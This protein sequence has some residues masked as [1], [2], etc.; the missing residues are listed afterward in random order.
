MAPARTATKTAGNGVQQPVSQCAVRLRGQRRILAGDVETIR[1]AGQG[2]TGHGIGAC[3]AATTTLT[4]FADAAA[5]AELLWIAERSKRWIVLI[6][7]DYRITWEST[8]F[9]R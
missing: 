5:A 4:V 3:P 6:R 2:I 8:A 1:F 7:V 9:D